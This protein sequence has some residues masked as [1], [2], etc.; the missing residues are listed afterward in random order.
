MNTFNRTLLAATMGC[1][2]TM[3][4]QVQAAGPK[5]GA[6]VGATVSGAVTAAPGTSG[7]KAGADL[8]A[9][10]KA[11]TDLRTGANA[12]SGAD[13]KASTETQSNVNPIAAERANDKSAQDARDKC[14]HLTGMEMGKCISDERNKSAPGQVRSETKVEGSAQVR[15]N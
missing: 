9:D 1:L 15:K 4:A 13:A 10:T 3:G 6:A 14:S 7:A 5:A 2:F 12:K 11:S 8:S